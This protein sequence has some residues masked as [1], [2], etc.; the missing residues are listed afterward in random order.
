MNVWVRTVG[1]EDDRVV[2]SDKK[3]GIRVF[4]WQPDSAHL[5]HIQDKGG[6]EN[7]HLYQ[8]DTATRMTKDLTPF[9]GVQVNVVDVNPYIQ[10]EIL[11]AINKRDRRLHDV[12]RVDLKSGE[13]TLDTEN[14]GDVAGFSA[15]KDLQVRGAVAFTP[16]GGQEIRVRENSK[17]P[18]RAVLKWGPE[19]GFGGIVGFHPDGKHLWLIHGVGANAARLTEMDIASG[20]E[21]TLV[22]DPQ[23]DVMEAMIHP[24]TRNLEAASIVRA[25]TEWVL[26]DKSLQPDFEVLRKIHDADFAIGGRALDDKTWMVVYSGDDAPVRYY[27]YDRERKKATFL[28]SARPKLEKYRLAK[29]RPVSFKA[30]DGLT[31]HGY[32]TVPAGA[33]AKNLPMLML[34]H[35]GPWHRDSWGFDP[36]VQWLANRG[37]G[38]L[39]VNFRGSTGYGKAHLNAGDREWA[40]KMHTDLVDGKAWAIAQG[41]A[42]PKRFCIGG[43][44]YGGYATLV[45]LAFTPDEFTCGVDI[46]GPSS[47]I[48]LMANLPPYWIPFRSVIERRVGPAKDEDFLKSRSPLFKAQDIKAP[49]IIAQ[50]ANDPRVKQAESDQIVAAMR[51]NGKEVQYIVFPDEGHGFARPEN[52]LRF[53]AATEAFLSKHLGGTAEA[54][55]DVEK[56][57]RFLK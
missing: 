3:R 16:T 28:F 6:D 15:D 12:Y 45:A 18:W 36:L 10:N 41:I 11:V 8:T 43:G 52:R 54:P 14:S 47:L 13:L 22:Q 37:Y 29:M 30:R 31:I 38:V 49:L 56:V 39:Q 20:A 33:Q 42:D 23:Y 32:L 46:V 24:K 19:D 35:G 53:C 21:K 40:A 25:R 44:S 2:T 55:A 7:W 57:D 34:V 27:A 9:A 50:G 1:Q 4:Y 48:T 26:L 51:K 5:L 17:A